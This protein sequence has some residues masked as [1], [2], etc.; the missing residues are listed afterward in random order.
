M[1]QVDD[2]L[3]GKVDTA[4]VTNL[5]AAVSDKADASTVYDKTEVGRMEFSTQF[6]K[7]MTQYKWSSFQVDNMLQAKADSS[8]V[9]KHQ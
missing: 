4:T 6:S 3:S 1:L 7:P 5:A 8:A 2:F 9:S